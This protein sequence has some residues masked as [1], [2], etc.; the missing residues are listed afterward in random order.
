MGFNLPCMIVMFRLASE[1]LC[2]AAL[3]LVCKTSP[4]PVKFPKYTSVSV[5]AAL[6]HSAAH[7]TGVCVFHILER[8]DMLASCHFFSKGCLR[9]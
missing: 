3:S 5:F 1:P 8:E 7:W 6:K 4:S 9:V 2:E